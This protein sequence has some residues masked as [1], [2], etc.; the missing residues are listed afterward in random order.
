LTYL[1]TY[2]N[3]ASLNGIDWKLLV[4]VYDKE[5]KKECAIGYL[6]VGLNNMADTIAR[7]ETYTLLK[8][9]KKDRPGGALELLLRIRPDVCAVS[10]PS[11]LARACTDGVE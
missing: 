1:L 8:R 7:E 4:D 10:D 6:E 3:I 11:G 2:R 5:P 9:K